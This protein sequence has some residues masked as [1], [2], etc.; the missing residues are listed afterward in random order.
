MEPTISML[1]AL[2]GTIATVWGVLNKAKQ[3]EQHKD[4]NKAQTAVTVKVG[5]VPEECPEH[6]PMITL[7]TV[8]PSSIQQGTDYGREPPS[9]ADL[10]DFE[11]IA[12][13]DRYKGI[14]DPD[15]LDSALLGDLYE[16]S[17]N[18]MHWEDPTDGVISAQDKERN[19]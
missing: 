5:N 8:S 15:Q 3:R 18:G 12:S 13:A 16:V 4:V 2:I 14:T 7:P 19:E 10:L 17:S 11:P 6:P 1:I 9:T